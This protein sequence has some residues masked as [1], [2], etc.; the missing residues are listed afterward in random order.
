MLAYLGLVNLILARGG[1]SCPCSRAS[2][3]RLD[4]PVQTGAA[5][6]EL[7][8]GSCAAGNPLCLGQKEHTVCETEVKLEI[9]A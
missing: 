6:S 3:T 8:E 7:R 5:R 4:D 1:K 2:Y 9:P